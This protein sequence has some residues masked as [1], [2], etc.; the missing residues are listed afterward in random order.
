MRRS[1]IRWWALALATV[2]VGCA[3]PASTPGASV[4]PTLA[5]TSSPELPSASEAAQDPHLVSIGDRS[6]WLECTGDGSPTVILE[7]GMG[8]DHRTW[9]LVQPQLPTTVRV[10]AYDRAGV[11]ESDPV[12][13]TRTAADA[14]DDLHLLLEAA[15]IEPPYVV[16][17]F[18]WGGLIS[19]LYAATYPDEI[20][21]LVLVEANHPLEA[22]QF[23][24]HL[25]PEQIE[26]DRAASLDN[27]ENMDPFES[28]EQAKAADPLPNVP[29]VVVTAGQPI[30]WPPDW[31]AETFNELR[32]AQQADLVTFTEQGTQI[33]AENSGHF[34][35]SEQ[36]GA[37]ID[38]IERVLESL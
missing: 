31:D 23:E 33:R 28:F 26:A 5:A 37:I 8:G 6:L 24:A 3:A 18:S 4:D 11:G 15:A 13:G 12:E 1:R 10:C 38:A 34:V 20:A 19:Q 21:G 9:D 27:P 16:V 22:E 14:V 7:S 2:L 36:P 29:L 35:P 30:E 17:G 32:A 25:T